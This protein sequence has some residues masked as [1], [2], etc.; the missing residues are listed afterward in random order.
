VGPIEAEIWSKR[1]IF[2]IY[3]LIINYRPI[4][5]LIICDLGQ[6]YFWPVGPIFSVPTIFFDFFFL[7]NKDPQ[8]MLSHKEGSAQ[9]SGF[10][11]PNPF[12]SLG[13]HSPAIVRKEVVANGTNLWTLADSMAAAAKP[14]AGVCLVKRMVESL[15]PSGSNFSPYLTARANNGT[16]GNLGRQKEKEMIS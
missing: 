9:F 10:F 1:N 2:L 15:I 16:W 4:I 12:Q 3:N 11:V 8:K 14:S 13:L 6:Y 7:A 5:R